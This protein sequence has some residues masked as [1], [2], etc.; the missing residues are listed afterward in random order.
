MPSAK[1]WRLAAAAAAALVLA[2]ACGS[3]GS[4]GASG[5]SGSS[6]TRV[7]DAENGEVEI[8]ARPRR[9]V[10]TG[11]AVPVL[12]EL[13]APLVGI[14]SWK[15]GIPMMSPADRASYDRLAKVAGEMAAETN[16]EAIARADPDLIVIGVPKPV[17]GD[18]NMKRL[19]SIAPVVVLGPSSP[20]DW[21]DLSRRQAD[22][23]GSLGG[24]TKAKAA[25]EK[26]AGEVAA[27]YRGTLA[28][29]RFGHVGGYGK[30]AAGTFMR[31]YAG[32]WG[33]NIAEDV[34]VR[35]Y[36]EVKDKKGGGAGVSE[37]PSIEEV[38]TSL[39]GADV[40]TYTLEPDGTVGQAV[41]YVLESRMWKD[42][43]AVKRG[44]AI[45]LRYTQ[46]ATYPSAAKA[47]DALDQALAPLATP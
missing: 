38:S 19:E 33:T 31:E 34:G 27:K 39:G 37:Y 32:S 44:R 14:S 11:Y 35:Y 6:R 26:R 22:A 17:L 13:G 36:G 5:V 43:P 3:G 7:F 40:I 42:L 47:L 8:P 24:Y 25:Y 41:E 2:S 10:A 46:A 29:L 28:K 45:G 4:D 23:A 9:V 16:Y 12:I 21:R 1:P 20:S 15:R 18:L 30:V